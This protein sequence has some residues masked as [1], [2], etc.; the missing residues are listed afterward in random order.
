M[1]DKLT[2][3]A[4]GAFALAII[5]AWV[6]GLVGYIWNIVKLVGL[7]TSAPTGNGVEA[8]MRAVGIIF[9]PLGAVAGYL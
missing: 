7:A 3:G 8:I 5:A 6:A 4:S 1:I 2:L 9:A